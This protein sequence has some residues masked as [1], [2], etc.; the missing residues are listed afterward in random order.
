MHR[1]LVLWLLL[2]LLTFADCVFC[3]ARVLS[4]VSGQRERKVDQLGR[5]YGTGRRKTSVARV[6]IKEGSGQFTVNNKSVVEY[7]PELQRH[8][9][10]EPLKA[11]ETAG[12]FDI[13]CT[14]EGGGITGQAGAVR[15]GL[16]RALEAF[17]PE[18]RPP[19]SRGK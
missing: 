10:L 4:D 5:A 12:K 3:V 9:A 15:L 14:A 19:L 11:T 7:F 8:H 13:I 17:E 6:W 2:L 18:L 1:L 16:S